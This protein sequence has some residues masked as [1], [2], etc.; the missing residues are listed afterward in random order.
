MEASGALAGGGDAAQQQGQA[1]AGQQQGQGQDLGQLYET[2]Q[3][4]PTRD[5]LRQLLQQQGQPEA[6]QEQDP[7]PDLSFL[8]PQ[9]PTFDPQMVGQE[10]DH[11]IAQRVQAGVEQALQQ[12]VSPIQQQLQMQ[13][14][15]SKARDL[16]AEFP[17]LENEQTATELVKTAQ[18]WAQSIGQPDLGNDPDVWRMVYMAGLAHEAAQAEAAQ[19]PQAATLEGSGAFPG[20]SQGVDPGDLIVNARREGAAGGRSSSL[21]S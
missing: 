8:D 9:D 14:R 17:A 5:D 6:G 7:G 12:H 19:P 20:G 2:I 3:S 10:L 13:Q 21:W 4:L 11:L 16:A 18:Q 1:D 15:E